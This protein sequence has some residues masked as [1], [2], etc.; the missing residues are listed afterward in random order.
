MLWLS[1]NV[2][3]DRP[4]VGPG[5][6]EYAVS[7]LP[8]KLLADQFSREPARRICFYKAHYV[9]RINRWR[10]VY[11]QMNVVGDT[12]DNQGT[13]ARFF[14]QRSEVGADLIHYLNIQ[15]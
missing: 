8:T 11:Q 4:G 10:Q 5:N 12:V 15:P 9:R 6:T 3:P 13:A 7:F 1:P 2:V 14:N